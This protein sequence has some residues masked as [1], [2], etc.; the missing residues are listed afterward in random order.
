MCRKVVGV[1][2]IIAFLL[3][4]KATATQYAFQVNFTDKNNTPYSLSLPL[5]FL[6]PR[7]IARRTTQ[8]IAID[9][10]D[11]PVNPNYIDS[12]ITLTG[13]ILHESSRWLNLC[14]ILLPDSSLIHNL[15]SK[16]YIKSTKMVGFY[17]GTLHNK[18]SSGPSAVANKTSSADNVYYGHT[19]SQTNLVKGNYLHDK[20]YNG[21]GKLIAVL[22]AG[23]ISADT[24]HGFDSLWAD[25][26]VLDQHNFTLDTSYIFAYDDHGTKVLSTMA[27]YVPDTYVGSAPLATYALYVT[28]DNHSEQPIELLNMLCAAERADSVG[29]DVITTS[30]GYDT[31][32]NPDDNFIFVLDL[33]GKSTIAAKAA[34][35]ATK[36]GILFVAT[37]GNEGGGP[38]N[39]IL[40]PGDADSALTV[41][42]VEI[43]GSPWTTS[44][45]GPNAVGQVKPDVCGLGHVASIF[46]IG[47]GGYDAQEDGTSF[48]T[49]QIAGWAACLWE[50][51]PLAT[52]YEIRRAIITCAS[53][54]LTPGPQIGYG[55]PDFQCTGQV[56]GTQDTP[57]P[58][59]QSRWIIASPVPFNNEITISAEP[60][61]NAYVDFKLT[62]ITGKTVYTQHSYMY[63][64]Y[65]S[66]F[67][68]AVPGLPAGVY[69]L[70]A[71]SPT[72][73]Q[74]VKLEKR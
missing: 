39:R 58:F 25:G 37:A 40:T 9:S 4:E 12:V 17:A 41:G 15:D 47:T 69:I 74:V 14:V 32:D 48:S 54:Y 71:V 43:L 60:N 34:N 8:G 26:R 53:S 6:S 70:K 56:L 44:G 13:G 31:F 52:P 50:A 18:V 61:A 24:H 36:K 46:N 49:P 23:F 42:S 73:Q 27:G 22:D 55:I 1:W 11:I 30:L 65:N 29:A 20:G 10:S 38:W 21:A 45:V 57:A 62:D 35:M 16:P 66:P 72:Q 7:A 67:T 63:K 19:W 64:G 5:W 51:N 33:D 59:T 2:L 3:C 68:I 28:E